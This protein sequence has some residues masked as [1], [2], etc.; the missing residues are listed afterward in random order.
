MQMEYLERKITVSGMKYTLGGI[1]SLEGR[2]EH[3][4]IEKD[5]NKKDRKK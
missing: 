1:N 2:L 3:V 5:K 4:M